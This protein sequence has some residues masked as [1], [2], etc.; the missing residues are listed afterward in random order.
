MFPESELLCNCS[1]LLLQ[2]EANKVNITVIAVW[3]HTVNVTL[4]AKIK[5]CQLTGREVTRIRLP[6]LFLM[7]T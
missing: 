5:N 7:T 3:I 6:L 1:R 4:A 2:I